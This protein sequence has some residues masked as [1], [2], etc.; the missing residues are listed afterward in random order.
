MDQQPA[1]RRFPELRWGLVVPMAVVFAI[2]SPFYFVHELFVL[3]LLGM[4]VV[5]MPQRR[6]PVMNLLAALA[7][8]IVP[9]LIAAIVSWAF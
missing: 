5:W 1:P 8:G 9:Y 7:L 3:G 2:L 6:R 4:W